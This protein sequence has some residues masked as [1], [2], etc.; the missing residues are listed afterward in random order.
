MGRPKKQL[1]LIT[2][3]HVIEKY[4]RYFNKNARAICP[5]CSDEKKKRPVQVVSLFRDHGSHKYPR[6]EVRRKECP[7][8]ER[9]WKPRVKEVT[10]W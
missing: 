5:Y 8:C 4:S 7:E 10:V 9:I 1:D 2:D 3:P 6:Y